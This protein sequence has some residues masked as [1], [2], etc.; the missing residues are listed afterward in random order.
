VPQP[1]YDPSK[2]HMAYPKEQYLGMLKVPD[3]A[4][5]AGASYKEPPVPA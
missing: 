4:I 5:T 2:P 1:D 3:A